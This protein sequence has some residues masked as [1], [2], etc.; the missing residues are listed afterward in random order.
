MKICKRLFT[1]LLSACLILTSIVVAKAEDEKSQAEDLSFQYNVSTVDS[2]NDKSKSYSEYGYREYS[3]EK[4]TVAPDKS[5]LETVT[6]LEKQ[7]LFWNQ[8]TDYVEYTVEVTTAA[9]YCIEWDYALPEDALQK[10]TR[11]LYVDGELPFSEATTLAF[12]PSFR[13]T[14]EPNKN[15]LGDETWPAQELIQR[16]ET[17]LCESSGGLYDEPFQ[18][19]L[20]Q[21]V[22]TFRLEYVNGDI[23]LGSM[24]LVAPQDIPS[25]DDVVQEYTK[26]GYS[27]AVATDLVFQA[28]SVCIEKN[29]A[30]VRRETD[31]DPLTIPYTPTTRSLNIIGGNRWRS[32]GESITLE[33]EIAETGLYKLGFRVRQDY[34]NGLPTYREL[35]IDGDVPFKEAE[36]VKFSFSSKWENMIFAND[37]GKPYLLYLEEGH[38]TLTLTATLA[39]MYEIISSLN[40]D[41]LC[42]SEILRD[43]YAI[44]GTDPDI[45]YNYKLFKT[46]PDL[47]SRMQ[48]LIESLQEKYTMLSDMCGSPP[49]MANSFLTVIE[50]LESMIADPYRI[51]RKLSD[52][53]TTLS[54]L[55]SWYSDLLGSPLA[56]DS[57]R[58][59]SEDTTWDN[60][61]SSFWSRLTGVVLRFFV[62]FFK[63]Y[64]NVGT[65]LFSDVK[66]TETIDVWVAYGAEWVEQ[67]QQLCDMNFTPKTGIQVSMN[68]LPSGQL[69]AGSAN[70][71]ML[72]ITS[73]KAPD[74]ALGVASASPVEFAIRETVV[75]LSDFDDFEEVSQRF[76][77]EIM[78][79]VEYADGY[80][81]L[82][83]TMNFTVMFYRKD[84]LTEN[85]ITLP[86][87]WEDV[88]NITLPLLYQNNL[89]F[90]CPVDFNM[91]L[92]QNNGKHYTDDGFYS[93]LNSPEAYR[94][95]SQM[96][97]LFCSYGVPVSADFYNRFRSGEMPIG[98]SNFGTYILLTTAAPELGGKWGI[99]PI[100][101]NKQEDGTINRSAGG[102]SGQM[103]MIMAQTEKK[104]ASW[105]FLKWW[106]SDTTQSAYA[107][108]IESLIGTDARWVSANVNAFNSLAWNKDDTQVISAYWK[109][110]K[111][112]PIVLGGYF[113]SRHINNAWSRIISNGQSVRA[114]LSEAYNDINRELRAKQEEY[115][116]VPNEK[117]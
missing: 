45:N 33:I 56:I 100:P 52:L 58:L 80:Y 54:N 19:Y 82:P 51:P 81:A 114:S 39:P 64:E 66:I 30:S 116:V 97:D 40:E 26:N 43:I 21:G 94:G 95:L 86:S 101:G 85:K 102:L 79:P 109:W 6:Y 50:Q 46:I 41:T 15:S 93:A 91:F 72:S 67:L 59:A 69:N 117:K 98:I 8:T 2:Y 11:I 32:G 110:A 28:E 77:P 27:D 92:Y 10:A 44:T 49:V 74:V 108:N 99:A 12:R 70:V 83:E 17:N 20:K 60:T 7:G 25:Y 24:R 105:E 38:H 112:Q 18:F 75:D 104:T 37:Q 36:A 65:F 29:A 78:V 90:Y 87:T 14:G 111:E 16:W 34:N 47:E 9:L 55:G 84:V 113:T 13:D 5:T 71:L 53:E 89:E 73:G 3:G 22:H 1:V 68:V 76:I 63:D 106:T 57:L 42:V 61:H 96:T 31:N 4:I 103:C 115:G 88:R 48:E 23:Y 107:A 35:R 62:S